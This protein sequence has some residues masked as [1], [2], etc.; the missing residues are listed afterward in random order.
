[1]LIK[2]GDDDALNA[3]LEKYRWYSYKLVGNFINDFPEYDYIRDELHAIIFYGTY[4]LISKYDSD[5]GH[6]YGYWKKISLRNIEK[7]IEKYEKYNSVISLDYQQSN[8]I[9]SLHDVVGNEDETY[10]QELLKQV[11]LSIIYNP[12]NDFSKKEQQV[13]ELYLKGF[14]LK[15]I[16]L[17]TDRSKATIYRHFKQAV[18]K[19]GNVMKD[20]NK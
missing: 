2:A 20:L 8:D 7:Y 15:D 6:F 4:D 17:I 11:Y 16:A 12:V 5:K 18:L 14:D 13:I 3:F 9:K 19:I 10:R 1:M